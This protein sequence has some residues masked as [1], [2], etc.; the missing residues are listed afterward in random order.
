MAGG[1]KGDS[2]QSNWSQGLVS[3][4]LTLLSSEAGGKAQGS[5]EQFFYKQTESTLMQLQGGVLDPATKAESGTIIA[6]ETSCES[7]RRVIQ[8]CIIACIVAFAMGFMP[9]VMVGAVAENSGG[10]DMIMK[11]ILAIVWFCSLVGVY[12]L[13]GGQGARFL[14]YHLPLNRCHLLGRA[15]AKL[16]KDRDDNR[17]FCI[18]VGVRQ[19]LTLGTTFGNGQIVGFM[20]GSWSTTGDTSF[21]PTVLVVCNMIAVSSLAQLVPQLRAE[22]DIGFANANGNIFIYAACTAIGK[23]F[24]PAPFCSIICNAMISSGKKS[25]EDVETTWP[26]M[27]IM[28]KRFAA[29][30]IA[31]QSSKWLCALAPGDQGYVPPHVI[32]LINQCLL[33]SWEKGQLSPQEAEIALRFLRKAGQRN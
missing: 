33:E 14:A 7:T 30:G 19:F 23:F 22:R 8:T 25:Y 4:L 1:S 31:P 28:Q 10:S 12:F 16:S 13:E 27:K 15:R 29:K 20:G 6:E 2:K 17:D 11:V 18:Y 21:G 5:G 26:T 32:C 9:V 3:Q 24:N